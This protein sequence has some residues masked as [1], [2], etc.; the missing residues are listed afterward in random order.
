M[1]LCKDCKHFRRGEAF[2]DYRARCGRD[3]IVVPDYVYGINSYKNQYWC[4]IER[5]QCLS[6]CGEKGRFWEAKE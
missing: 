2:S 4:E 1:K 6:C 3:E 5:T